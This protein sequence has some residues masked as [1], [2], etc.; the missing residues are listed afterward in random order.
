MLVKTIETYSGHSM[1]SSRILNNTET[2]NNPR[3][4]P[5]YLFPVFGSSQQPL[6]F[7]SLKVLHFNLYL[8]CCM[9]L[10]LSHTW[11][12]RSAF[13]EVALHHKSPWPHHSLIASCNSVP[14]SFAKELARHNIW[15]D[16]IL[17]PKGRY[18][19]YSRKNN[20]MITKKIIMN[21]RC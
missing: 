21:I 8:H 5:P 4:I 13:I 16:T 19:T 18:M 6:D 14:N 12:R 11:L 2:L 3:K 7:I 1:I 15:D 10:Y 20:F 9:A 17:P